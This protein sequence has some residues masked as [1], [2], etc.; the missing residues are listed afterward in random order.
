M[1][2]G[3]YLYKVE[4]LEIFAILPFLN[5]ERNIGKPELKKYILIQK[6]EQNPNVSI[7]ELVVVANGKT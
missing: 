1:M 2:E 6:K 5:G 4:F 3:L 7:S